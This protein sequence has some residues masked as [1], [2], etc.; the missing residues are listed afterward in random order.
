MEGLGLSHDI[1][2]AYAMTS[3]PAGPALRERR[4]RPVDPW[5]TVSGWAWTGYFLCWVA[6]LAWQVL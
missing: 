5:L 3:V 2:H 6:A 4:G 1:C